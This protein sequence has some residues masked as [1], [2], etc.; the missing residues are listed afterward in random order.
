MSPALV[1]LPRKINDI[2]LNEVEHTSAFE[3]GKMF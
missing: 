1:G 3:P 2:L